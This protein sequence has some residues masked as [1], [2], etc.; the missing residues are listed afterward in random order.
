MYTPETRVLRH[1]TRTPSPIIKK[2]AIAP[3]RPRIPAETPTKQPVFNKLKKSIST[4][5]SK[6]NK[7]EKPAAAATTTEEEKEEENEEKIAVPAPARGPYDPITPSP[8]RN[9]AGGVRQRR[10]TITSEERRRGGADW[11]ERMVDYEKAQKHVTAP[12]E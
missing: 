7:K 12:Y 6:P 9:E 2:P 8:L 4:F 10:G 1:Y 5:F 11:A 3:I